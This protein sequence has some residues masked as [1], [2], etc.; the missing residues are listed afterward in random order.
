MRY[1][2]N[3]FGAIWP[4]R[5]CARSKGIIWMRVRTG[6]CT[7]DVTCK[8]GCTRPKPPNVTHAHISLFRCLHMSAL[9]ASTI[10]S[11]RCVPP[12]P[13][14]QRLHGCSEI[15]LGHLGYAFHTA[16]RLTKRYMCASSELA[17]TKI[18][19]DSLI[20]TRQT[21]PDVTHAMVFA[22]RCRFQET[23]HT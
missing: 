1:T 9:V 3:D 12:V 8:R 6:F 23:L 13:D 7:S 10:A 4:H 17:D 20:R 5:I 19:R 11:I 16:W 15:A 2:H 21:P 14:R 18:Y 22:F